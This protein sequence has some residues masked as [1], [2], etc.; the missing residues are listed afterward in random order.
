[1]SGVE[2]VV[3]GLSHHAT[4]LEV[5]ERLSVATEA[6]GQEIQGLLG[7]APLSE[8][9]L[10]STCN[11]VELY[12]A[13]SDPVTALKAIRAYLRTRA[14]GDDLDPYLYERSGE[15]AVR[16]AF[17][18]ASSLDSM[19][20]GEP[21]ILGQVKEA[22]QASDSAGALGTLLGRCFSRAFAVAKR[23]RTETEIAAGT[24][25]ISSVAIELA[26]K[27]FGD[28]TERRAM[29]LG[30][31]EMGEAAAK[32]L[33]ARG[34]RLIVVN[35]SPERAA[36]LAEKLGVEAAP[37]E[38]LATELS[39]ADVVIT[40]TASPRFVITKDMMKDV[41][42]A[43]RR[44]PLFLIDIA[45]PRDVDPR[46][47]DLDNVFLYDVDDLSEVAG[48]NLA[49]RKR[50]AD[51]AEAIVS[52]ETESFERW[53]RSLTL[54]PTIK[55]LRDRFLH[56]AM[57]ELARTKPRL[58]LSER[59]EQTLD[60]MMNTLVNKLLHRPITEL[61]AGEDDPETTALIDAT[62]RLFDL[63]E[64]RS[65]PPETSKNGA[66]A[67]QEQQEQEGAEDGP[68]LGELA[69]ATGRGESR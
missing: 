62:R 42:R 18:V 20:V 58:T 5:R 21:Q 68:V 27:I 52:E 63:E 37:Y 7:S 16:H 41:M 39:R 55:G 32:S 40:S 24:V 13:T 51:H 4:P 53:R 19:V 57:A 54:A 61:K 11:R 15:D 17:R 9:V 36:E 33:V 6:T 30:A 69:G 12:A 3:V 47:G 59:D 14:G 10:L 46:A 56:L 49:A 43:R 65:L 67:K 26:A 28:L 44:R 66:F 25:S 31:G 48:M 64:R 22:Y 23:V 2:I 38:Q 35:R 60:A 8:G 1:M 29:L 45:V 50:A 34:V